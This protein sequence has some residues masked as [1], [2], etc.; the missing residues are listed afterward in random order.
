MEEK[1]AVKG[2]SQ[3]P[4]M[5]HFSQPMTFARP[6]LAALQLAGAGFATAPWQQF[7]VR[8]EIEPNL[9]HKRK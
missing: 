9:S 2:G 6:D 8:K 7:S 3:A 4:D 5:G 1:W